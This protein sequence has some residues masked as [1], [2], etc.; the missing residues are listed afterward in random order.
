MKRATEDITVEF[1]LSE[2]DEATGSEEKTCAWSDCSNTGEHRAP[3]S[4]D[5]INDFYWFCLEHVRIYN[6]SW[7]YYEGMSD[8]QVEAL[9]RS[10]STWNR[11]SWPLGSL[12]GQPK[13]DEGPEGS[14]K[15]FSRGFDEFGDPFG[16][17]DEINAKGDAPSRGLP[18]TE[19]KALALLD[20]SYP[21]TL[22]KVK[23]RYKELVKR[24]HPDATGG[25]K[26]AEER[27]K[28]INEA[29]RI[30]MAYLED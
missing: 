10:D 11:P 30:I 26:K 17:F 27:F 12:N 5:R 18:E 14:A 9:V 4:R 29:Y 20:L 7:N 2:E 13:G 16:F 19:K 1:P 22:D 23:A 24:Y 6:R 28:Q 15:R 21:L 3:K 25:D 8:E